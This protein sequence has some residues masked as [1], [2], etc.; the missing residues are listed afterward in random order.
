MSPYLKSTSFFVDNFEEVK[1]IIRGK[2]N[3]YVT[4]NCFIFVVKIFHRKL[5][6]I[7]PKK[8]KKKK[9]TQFPSKERTIYEYLIV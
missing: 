5:T 7:W 4:D 8:K 3:V 1:L 9:K 6:T 2:C